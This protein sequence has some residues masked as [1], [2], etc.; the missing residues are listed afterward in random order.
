M[1]WQREHEFQCG[2]RRARKRLTSPFGSFVRLLSQSPTETT[3]TGSSGACTTRLPSL[4]AVS[5][6]EAMVGRK[7]GR[8]SQVSRDQ[9]SESALIETCVPARVLMAMSHNQGGFRARS[10]FWAKTR[11]A[12]AGGSAPSPKASKGQARTPYIGAHHH[13]LAFFGGSGSACGGGSVARHRPRL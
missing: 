5:A 3:G 6:A 8:R 4:F 1:T 2:H 12:V 13:Y 9:L 10:R 7:P 11:P